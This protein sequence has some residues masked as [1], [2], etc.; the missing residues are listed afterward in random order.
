MVMGGNG[1][2]VTV[3]SRLMESITISQTYISPKYIYEVLHLKFTFNFLVIILT[4]F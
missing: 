2:T 4:Y 1:D 3:T